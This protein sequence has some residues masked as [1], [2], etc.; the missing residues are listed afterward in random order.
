MTSSRLRQPRPPARVG[1]VQILTVLIVS[2][3]TTAGCGQ[4]SDPTSESPSSSEPTSSVATL[5]QTT[6]A[7]TLRGVPVDQVRSQTLYVPSYSHIYLRDQDRTINLAT[8]LS[9]RNVSP[10]DSITIT[11]VDYFD[12]EGELVRHYLSEPEPLAPL[13]STSYIVRVDDIR[14][15]VGANFIVSWSADRPVFAPFIETVHITTQASL[16]I[17]FTSDARVL[18]EEP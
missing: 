4:A 11:R 14:G 16:G 3:L 17:S 13:Q 9:V 15:G 2:L 1:R 18:Y 7:D 10:S 6:P 8:T 5:P 12:N